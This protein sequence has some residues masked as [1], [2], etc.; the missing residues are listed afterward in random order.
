MIEL[1]LRLLKNSNPGDE[2]GISGNASIAR[3][4]MESAVKIVTSYPGTP[5]A[6]IIEHLVIVSDDPDFYTEWS[7][8]EKVALEVAAAAAMSGKRSAFITKHVGMNV[9]SDSLMHICYAGLNAG[10]VIISADD[11]GAFNSPIE[12]DSRF[13]ARMS[14][15]LGL[16]ASNQ[17]EAKDMVVN[18]LEISE[19]VKLPVFIRLT[20]RVLYGRGSVVMGKL[21]NRKYSAQFEKDKSRW[22]VAGRNAVNRHQWLHGQQTHLKDIVEY[23]SFNSIDWANQKKYG[24]IAIGVSYYYAKEALKIL[25]PIKDKISILKLGCFNPLPENLIKMFLKNIEEVIIIEELEPFIEEKVKGLAFEIDKKVKI[26]GKLTCHLPETDAL[27]T[28]FVRD[29]IINLWLNKTDTGSIAYEVQKQ[30]E[31]LNKL[32][33]EQDNTFCPGCPHRASYFVLRESLKIVNQE[34]IFTND[35]GCY[36][37]GVKKP[38]SFADAV[39]CMGASIGIGSGLYHAKIKQRIIAI[40]GDSTFLHA[41][42]PALI[43]C[44]Y[45]NTDILIYIL[46]NRTIAMTGLQPYPGIGIDAKGNKAKLTKIEDI[47]KACN[48]D[49]LAIIDP[50]KVN[51]AKKILARA[52]K[53]KGQR[54]V[55]SRKECAQVSRK[56]NKENEKIKT[57]KIEFRKCKKCKLCILSIACPAILIRNNSFVINKYF[58]SGCGLCSQICPYGAIILDREK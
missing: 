48:V 27:N 17:Q 32:I 36:M 52:L 9:A 19:K 40:I 12:E 14:E 54:V 33:P 21:Q 20:N 58:C 29:V 38:F 4:I 5:C 46:D 43:N 26:Y 31:E 3:G 25:T 23:S 1:D 30:A 57:Y 55:I 18:A 6:E 51:K 44:C 41:G 47:V 28:E 16:E 24:I 53:M 56:I 11:P 8:N 22:F 39:F 7:I 13:F 45:T 10:M 15:I 50:F 49:H 35:I 37:L 34:F 2:V 42:I